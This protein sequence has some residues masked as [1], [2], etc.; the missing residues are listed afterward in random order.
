MNTPARL[1]PA[2]LLDWAKH[3]AAR[4]LQVSSRQLM[5]RTAAGYAIH[6]SNGS[7][8]IIFRVFRSQHRLI[9]PGC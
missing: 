8:S 1:I 6:G 3:R 5:A 2:L 7:P 4:E 9:P